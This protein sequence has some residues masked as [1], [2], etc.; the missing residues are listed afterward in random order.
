[1]RCSASRPYRQRL[2]PHAVVV[3]RSALDDLYPLSPMQ[4]GML[5]HCIESPELNLYVN[6]LSVAVEGL[7]V[8]RFCSAWQTLLERHE[9][10]TAFM[11][12][13]GLADPLQA[14]YQHAE[15]PIVE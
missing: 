5:F 6:Q 3:D 2:L 7:Q 1:M 14:V 4:Q 8:Q 12:R 10:R 9:V 11:W 15:L 13:D